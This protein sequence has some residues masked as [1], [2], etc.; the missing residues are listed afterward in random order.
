MSPFVLVL[1]LVVV[2]VLVSRCRPR[3]SVAK[4]FW[5]SP[6]F[7][8]VVVSIVAS[9]VVVVVAIVVM[10]VAICHFYLLS[11]LFSF[12][13]FHPRF[14]FLLAFNATSRFMIIFM[15]YCV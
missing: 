4:D 15:A 1:V 9:A 10:A 8:V 13:L 11:L 6:F 12:P 7:L 3:L 2:L 5:V 14:F